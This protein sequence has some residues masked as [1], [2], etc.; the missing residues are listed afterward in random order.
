MPLWTERTTADYEPKDYTDNERFSLV[1]KIEMVESPLPHRYW[2]SKDKDAR[3]YVVL[4]EG[5]EEDDP[6]ND[7]HQLS[8]FEMANDSKGQGLSRARLQEFIDELREYDSSAKSI[9][10]TH[11]EKHTA[12]FWDKL[13]DEGLIDSASMKPY[14]TTTPDGRLIRKIE[15]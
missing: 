8:L 4:Q 9:H 3:G 2:E 13:V 10:V 6:L 11:S 5:N 15:K 14:V 12:N 1:P 7:Y